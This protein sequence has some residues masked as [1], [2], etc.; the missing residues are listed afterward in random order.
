MEVGGG[1]GEGVGFVVQSRDLTI[2]R[3]DAASVIFLSL[4]LLIVVHF[5][6]QTYFY[7]VPFHIRGKKEHLGK[8]FPFFPEY[9]N[10]NF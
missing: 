2:G 10:L 1:E 3:R 7:L 9:L 5:L 8:C 6:R 4:S